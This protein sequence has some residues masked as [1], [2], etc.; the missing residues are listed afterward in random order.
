MLFGAFLAGAFLA[1]AFLAG[2]F[3]VESV[4]DLDFTF[5]ALED[6]LNF[7]LANSCSR[8]RLR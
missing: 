1:V 3:C 7:F 6:L 5:F 8:L 2:A 4:V